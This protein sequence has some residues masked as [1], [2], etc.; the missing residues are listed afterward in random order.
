[1]PAAVQY[2]T[3]VGG[4]FLPA[5]KVGAT[6]DVAIA[7]SAYCTVP[8]LYCIGA[9]SGE[10][11]TR[12]MSLSRVESH[13]GSFERTGNV[14]Y[15][16]V[17]YRRSSRSSTGREVRRTFSPRL[18]LSP[19][20]TTFVYPLPYFIHRPTH[21]LPVSSRYYVDVIAVCCSRRSRNCIG[22]IDQLVDLPHLL[23]AYLP[24]L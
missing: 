20:S 22:S 6:V 18:R 11:G 9:M 8:Y 3:T 23:P 1:M 13:S 2:C 24:I 14:T 4:C 5:G 16:G 19:R 17:L 7:S 15:H 10:Q 21:L 12:T